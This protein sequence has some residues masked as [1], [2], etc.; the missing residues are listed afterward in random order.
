MWIYASRQSIWLLSRTDMAGACAFP[1]PSLATAS[2]GI[3]GMKPRHRLCLIFHRRAVAAR[4]RVGFTKKENGLPQ[5][6]A[7]VRVDVAVA[8]ANRRLRTILPESSDPVRIG[9]TRLAN[10]AGTGR[11][12]PPPNG[13]AFDGKPAK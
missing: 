10:R 8:C 13:H 9:G 6:R 3:M 11:A 12:S 1:F 4:N 5:S 2:P 7:S